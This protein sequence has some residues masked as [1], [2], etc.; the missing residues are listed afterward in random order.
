MCSEVGSRWELRNQVWRPGARLILS[1]RNASA[2]LLKNASPV[3][4]GAENLAGRFSRPQREA[5]NCLIHNARRP[6]YAGSAEAFPG[7]SL[8]QAR[9][10]G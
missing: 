9:G 7:E 1:N 6:L 4:F 3:S 8:L 2:G 5:V 10:P